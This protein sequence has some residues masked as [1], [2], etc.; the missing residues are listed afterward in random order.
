MNERYEQEF[1][2]IAILENV[3]EAQ[4][5]ASILNEH[6][7]PHRIRSF[8]DTA[9]DGL[10]QFQMGWGSLF[11]PLSNKKEIFEILNDVRSKIFDHEE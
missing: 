5:I 8:H 7:I 10:F 2:N 11:A 1:I 6:N 9:Y 3:I 4:L